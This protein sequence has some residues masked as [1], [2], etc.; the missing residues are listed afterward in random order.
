MR[1]LRCETRAYGDMEMAREYR[2]TRGE[3]GKREVR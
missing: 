2:E 3:R 1:K